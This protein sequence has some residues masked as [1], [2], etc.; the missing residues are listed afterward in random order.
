MYT[1]YYSPGACSLAVHALLCSLSIPFNTVCVDIAKG[2]NRSPEYLKLNPRGQVPVLVEDGKILRESAVMA[3]YLADIHKSPLLPANGFERYKALEW[4][5]FYNSTLHQAYG[6]YFL[7][8]KRLEDAS[9]KDAACSL[10]ARRIGFLWR[11][12]EEQLAQSRYLCGDTLTLADVF[13]TVIAHWTKTISY[14]ITLGPNIRRL[15]G[16]VAALEWF[17]QAL[18]EE[19]VTYHVPNG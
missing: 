12:V 13:H 14:P 18:K 6:A 15:C 3:V 7:L 10:A 4:L 2:D 9:V 19:H 5:G 11:A 17:E 8:A 16:E 1:L